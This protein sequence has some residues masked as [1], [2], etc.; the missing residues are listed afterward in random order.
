M[1]YKEIDDIIMRGLLAA[2]L[3]VGQ[4]KSEENK[5]RTEEVSE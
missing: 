3:V 4:R 2:G 5:V 1:I